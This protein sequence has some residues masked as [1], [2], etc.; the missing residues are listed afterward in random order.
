MTTSKLLV[1]TENFPEKNSSLDVEPTLKVDLLK[2]KVTD[3]ASML[4]VSTTTAMPMETKDSPGLKPNNAVP[5]LNIEMTSSKL[6]VT[7]E[8]FPEMNSFLDAE[9]T[10]S[11]QLT[12]NK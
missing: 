10:S 2:Q 1:T 4:M 8:N 11:E 5:Q 6:L 12:K 9:P 7:T 3:A